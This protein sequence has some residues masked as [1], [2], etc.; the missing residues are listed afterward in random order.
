MEIDKYEDIYRRLKKCFEVSFGNGKKAGLI[1][2]GKV[3]ELVLSRR[4]PDYRN[5]MFENS[6]IE[7]PRD[8]YSAL[9]K[10]YISRDSSYVSGFIGCAEDPVEQF[11]GITNMALLMYLS[12]HLSK[13]FKF[14]G[15]DETNQDSKKILRKNEKTL[16]IWKNIALTD[17]IA[18]IYVLSKTSEEYENY[19]SYGSRSDDDKKP[20]FVMDLP[21]I[22]Q[23]CVHFGCEERKNLIV[24]NAQNAAR[25][26]LEKKLEL[27]QIKE[28]QLHKITSDLEN[29]GVLPEYA[30][31]LYEYVGA[32]PIE[33]IGEKI[34]KY[35][36]IIG[37]KLPE[38]ITSEDI[39]K[40][41]RCGLN[42]R[43][44]Y[45]FFIKMG[46]SKE[47]LNEI[48][49]EKKKISYQSV[50]KATEQITIEDFRE[51]SQALKG[52]DSRSKEQNEINNS[53]T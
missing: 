44:L 1:S 10:T 11:D 28:E 21:Y 20:T 14:K 42:E 25:S 40:L 22:G 3:R 36:N 17:I 30:G 41:G 16:L 49:G 31:K 19:F 8:L 53:R 51:A 48:S 50:V 32:M 13:E 23:L 6:L 2:V 38:Q 37:S 24:E 18:S 47:V 27:G 5:N 45:Y 33:F 9:E 34:K 39:K 7:V 26:V 29:E 12:N 15:N 43:E 4:T 46:A 35:R 52:I